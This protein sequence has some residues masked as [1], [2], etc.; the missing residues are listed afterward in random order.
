MNS[1]DSSV[2][3]TCASTEFKQC[4]EFFCFNDTCY[5][6]PN[7]GNVTKS[8]CGMSEEAAFSVE[9]K[10]HSASRRVLERDGTRSRTSP[11]GYGGSKGS[12]S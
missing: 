4:L 5:S 2:D 11:A 3:G 7:T 6:N 10:K 9:R 8:M 1:E 12:W